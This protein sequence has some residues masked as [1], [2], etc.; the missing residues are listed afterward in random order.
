MNIEDTDSEDDMRSEDEEDDDDLSDE[1][2]ETP[3]IE[4]DI[5]NWEELRTFIAVLSCDHFSWNDDE[6]LMMKNFYN[7]HIDNIFL[8]D[9][10]LKS[11]RICYFCQARVRS[12]KVQSPKVKTKRTWADTIITWATTHHHPDNWVIDPN[13]VNDKLKSGQ[14]N[15]LRIKCMIDYIM[16]IQN[17]NNLSFMINFFWYL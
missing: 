12:P 16:L 14:D 1:E 17:F 11:F 7:S 13:W 6:Y 3:D 4:D 10:S 8:L 9:L 15:L 2:K 5:N